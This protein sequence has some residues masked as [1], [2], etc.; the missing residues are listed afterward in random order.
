MP[1]CLELLFREPV[2]KHIIA[3][4]WVFYRKIDNSYFPYET[5]SGIFSLVKISLMSF[6]CFSFVFRLVFLFSK[7]S[8]LCNKNKI[9]R[10]FEHIKFIFLWKKDFTSERSKVNFICSRHRVISSI[11]FPFDPV[12][13]L[14]ANSMRSKRPCH[15]NWRF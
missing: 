12:G 4:I 3:Q 2:L 8:Y 11:Y 15:E 14:F 7:H 5:K 6:L 13:N 1:P 10:W 9:T